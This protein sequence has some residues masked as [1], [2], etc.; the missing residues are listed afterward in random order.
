[1]ELGARGRCALF[2]LAGL[3]AT[4]PVPSASGQAAAPA[5]ATMRPHIGETLEQFEARRRGLKPPPR[6]GSTSL[7]PDKQG[8]FGADAL[9]NGKKVR[10]LV[11]T[12]ATLV[13]LSRAD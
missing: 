1:M 9:I 12:G 2:L 6:R 7:V 13:A 11:D 3:F 8:H 4:G 5:N 10:V